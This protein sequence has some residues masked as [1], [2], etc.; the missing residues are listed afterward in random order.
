MRRG[1]PLDHSGSVPFEE[2]FYSVSY[3]DILPIDKLLEPKDYVVNGESRASDLAS[4][5]V[6]E[7]VGRGLT[8]IPELCVEH[9]YDP[10]LMELAIISDPG[11]QLNRGAPAQK[12]Y[13]VSYV[14]QRN[15]MAS[16][17]EEAYIYAVKSMGKKGSRTKGEQIVSH[18]ELFRPENSVITH[19]YPD[20]LPEDSLITNKYSEEE[21]GQ[22]PILDRESARSP[23]TW[24]FRSP[25][26]VDF[27]V[28][29][30][31]TFSPDGLVNLFAGRFF[32]NLVTSAP[33]SPDS[34]AFA[35]SR[36]MIMPFVRPRLPSKMAVEMPE[37]E[38]QGQPAGVLFLFLRPHPGN[39]DSS[40][41]WI[42]LARAL[43]WFFGQAT[44]RETTI[45][46]ALLQHYHE[47]TDRHIQIFS[48]LAH[49]LNSVFRK[50]NMRLGRRLKKLPDPVS[51]H[52]GLVWD[53]IAATAHIT[54]LFATSV[55][56]KSKGDKLM[57]T[58]GGPLRKLWEEDRLPKTLALVAGQVL[59][60]EDLNIHVSGLEHSPEE[61]DK[62][63]AEEFA[64]CYIVVGEMI[65]NLRHSGLQDL[66]AEFRAQH[67]R[68]TLRVEL[69]HQIEKG[70]LVSSETFD[71]L[72]LFLKE[73]DIGDT[74]FEDL[75]TQEEYAIC[76]HVE[77]RLGFLDKGAKRE[78]DEEA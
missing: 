45:H 78:E 8:V 68:D 31:P 66:S 39:K 62:L 27:I 47:E 17:T 14:M 75:S 32:H 29:E 38:V 65:R 25:E 19:R 23:D 46:A 58:F 56:F 3:D 73:L 4:E 37:E 9:K 24:H 18:P 30:A 20:D 71:I 13:F 77:L 57:E 42:E 61:V 22:G 54:Y 52:A 44:Q 67:E 5:S 41:D 15:Y 74:G 63:S 21:S 7:H 11:F 10:L 76:W 51:K 53:R 70:K 50:Q 59:V 6:S 60:D 33:E 36:L 26:F 16:Q 49:E 55:S 34:S 28:R 69:K 72:G 35:N 64:S 2:V 12:K 43:G 40:E 1:I 48:T